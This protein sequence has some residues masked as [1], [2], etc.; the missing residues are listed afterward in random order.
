MSHWTP[1]RWGSFQYWVAAL[2][3]DALT[4]RQGFTVWQTPVLRILWF[5]ALFSY[6][7]MSNTVYLD[8]EFFSEFF[9]SR[10]WFI[11]QSNSYFR[12]S[13]F[14]QNDVQCVVHRDKGRKRLDS[15]SSV[16]WDVRAV[17]SSCFFVLF[18]FVCFLKGECLR[19]RSWGEQTVSGISIHQKAV[20]SNNF[21]YICT[22]Q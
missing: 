7:F 2:L 1:T 19:G 8:L 4:I 10:K 14:Y 3:G 22:N 11:I 13:Y 18:C 5:I 15:L 6:Q 9:S 17:F 20:S 16:F 21:Q 12:Y